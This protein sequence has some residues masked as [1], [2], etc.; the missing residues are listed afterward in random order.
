MISNV[1][2]QPEITSEKKE[3]ILQQLQGYWMN[4]VWDL[5]D[6]AFEAYDSRKSSR[7]RKKRIDFT[8][9]SF[10]IRKELKYFFAIELTK[11]SLT[12]A[13]LLTYSFTFN[14]LSAFFS[15]YYPTIYSLVEIPYEKG[16]MKYKSYLTNIGVKITNSNGHIQSKY[17]AFFN[18]V[19]Q[20][21]FD[22]YDTREEL[23]KDIWDIR[24]IPNARYSKNKAEYLI[25]FDNIHLAYREAVKKYFKFLIT[26]FSFS[27]LK[28]ILRGIR[29]FIE[30]LQKYYPD[31]NSITNL[32][33][34]H[35]EQYLLYFNHRLGHLSAGTK[36]DYLYAV[37]VFIDY[38]QRTEHPK[39]P[40]KS[41]FTLFFKEDFP[42]QRRWN[43]NEIKY[44][45][46]SV[47]SQL[48]VL[49]SQNPDELAP[50]MKGTD[51]KYI[52]VIILLMATGWRIS[53]I[54]N[55]RYHNCLITD[56]KKNYYLQ[57]DIPKTEVKRHRIPIDKDVATIVQ[58]VIEQTKDKSTIENNPEKYLFVLIKGKRKGNPFYSGNVSR[59]LNRLAKRYN[60]VDQDGSIFHFRNHAFRHTKGVELINLG[61]NL[62]HIMKWFAHSTPEMTLVYAKI[63]D[64][65]LRRE[66][67][68][69]QKKK[70]P[71]L[72]VNLDNGQV[73]EMAM[74]EDLI[75][76]EY[77]RS[78]IEAVRV[79]LG[80]CLASKKEGCPYVVTPC[81]TCPNFCTSP[82]NLPDFEREIQYVEEHIQMT[83]NYPIYN[84]KTKE[85][86]DNLIKIRDQL[87]DGKSHRGENVKK[88]LF[89][90][91]IT[92]EKGELS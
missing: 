58:A 7:S 6:S 87:A 20:F 76:W 14:H 3:Q 37:K 78:N 89:D 32:Q 40:I 27:A 44:I 46:D 75:H 74:D 90:A 30:F 38:L 17:I 45:P 64:N 28:T 67:E 91:Q 8:S 66:W 18:R 48:E 73:N 1:A 86:L 53:D 77:M 2:Y 62:T 72:R 52:P 29:Y 36:S 33:R 85:Q 81:L 61:M 16:L 10:V 19:Y 63:A 56:N 9:F 82:D 70:G 5:R 24:K 42:K 60:I 43:E 26:S 49:L 41:V 50:P 71:L 4:D 57:G 13:T 15:K 11:G 51:K 65:T 35:V 23:E 59:A 84:E 55:L 39:A 54:L 21:L 80:F 22:F 68:K 83:Q 92:K 47:M 88:V 79:P 31:W 34:L 25:S 69:A 12:I